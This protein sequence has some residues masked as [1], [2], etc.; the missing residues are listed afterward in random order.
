MM[1]TIINLTVEWRLDPFSNYAENQ[2]LS[3]ENYLLKKVLAENAYFIKMNTK[4][5]TLM[6][7]DKS[8]LTLSSLNIQ[9]PH[10]NTILEI[11]ELASNYYEN[12]KLNSHNLILN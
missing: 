1:E 4:N 3:F 6:R 5:F 7:T 9:L 12:F 11:K 8:N 2:I 10:Q